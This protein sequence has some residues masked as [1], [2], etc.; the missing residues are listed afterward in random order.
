MKS[1][2]KINLY[3]LAVA[4]LLGV[5]GCKKVLDVNVDPNN[6]STAN[7][8]QVLPASQVEMA[9]QIGNDYAFVCSSWAQYWTNGTVVGANP[10]EFFTLQGS[11]IDRSYRNMYAR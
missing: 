7:P 4:I 6:P 8:E 10:I 2:F 5:S 1:I 9:T 11:D 3:T